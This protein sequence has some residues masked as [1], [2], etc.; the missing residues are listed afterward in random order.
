MGAA[1]ISL[2]IEGIFVY[3]LSGFCSTG[4]T[5]RYVRNISGEEIFGPFSVVKTPSSAPT[6]RGSWKR[7]AISKH[8]SD[9]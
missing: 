4:E 5:K 1:K 7:G 9:R 6:Y 3:F 8:P 2:D